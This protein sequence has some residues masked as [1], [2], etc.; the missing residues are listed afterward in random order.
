MKSITLVLFLLFLHCFSIS[1][2][3]FLDPPLD[4]VSAYNINSSST[5]LF[6]ERFLLSLQKS[7][8]SISN[9]I[10]FAD[11]AIIGLD[12]VVDNTISSDRLPKLLWVWAEEHE[13]NLLSPY[14]PQKCADGF[15]TES[16]SLNFISYNFSPSF[17]F[18][19]KNK[20]KT[21]GGNL[22]EIFE[23]PFNALE[24]SS[25]NG[26][27]NLSISLN[28]NFTF[29][30]NKIVSKYEPLGIFQPS[31][32]L[33]SIENSIETFVRPVS[34][35]IS[36]NVESGS[37]LFFLRA[38]VLREQ[39]FKNNVFNEIII[40]KRAFYNS[41]IFLNDERISQANMYV[42]DIKENKFGMKY[43]KSIP[44]KNATN[45]LYSENF[46]NITPIPIEK[47]K[48]S[49]SYVYEFNT[50]YNGVGRNNITLKIRDRFLNSFEV[51]ESI[52]SRGLTYD[53]NKIE[54]SF[55]INNRNVSGNN[56]LL[57]KSIQY[58]ESNLTIATISLGT[59]GILLIIILSRGYLR[60]I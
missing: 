7:N 20:T 22:Q 45:M 21:L 53:N 60:R 4:E 24:F 33:Y 30:Y 43:T 50:T 51:S 16:V 56:N 2:P 36:Y 3:Y 48:E 47:T 19:F 59:V 9:P 6:K 26:Y 17:N 52:L 31:C 5:S 10:I 35:T 18:S 25:G 40:S 14:D 8:S 12:P 23:I 38:P 55:P 32:E 28:G 37:V 27:D 58:T 57:R 44:M 54:N 39:W 41:K 29:T 34:Y 49:F 15:P 42:F 46:T 1:F 11:A 13:P